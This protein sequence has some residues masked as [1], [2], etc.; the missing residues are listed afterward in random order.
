MSIETDLTAIL[1]VNVKPYLE[2]RDA[3][4]RAEDQCDKTHAAAVASVKS[5]HDRLRAA[6]VC[7]LRPHR[8]EWHAA[9]PMGIHYDKE[10]AYVHFEGEIWPATKSRKG[11]SMQARPF[12]RMSFTPRDADEFRRVVAMLKAMADAATEGGL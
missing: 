11:Y 12:I 9:Y 2:S 7:A 5:Q 10:T 3:R 1:A 4:L 8:V 6:V